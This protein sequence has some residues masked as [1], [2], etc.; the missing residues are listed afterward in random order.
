MIIE[1]Y[2]FPLLTIVSDHIIEH[3]LSRSYQYSAVLRKH[4]EKEC[5]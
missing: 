1:E 2:L 5:E 4:F 3:F